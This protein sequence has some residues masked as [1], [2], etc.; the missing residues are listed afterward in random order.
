M[1]IRCKSIAGQR[2]TLGPG[3]PIIPGCELIKG[4]GIFENKEEFPFMFAEVHGVA[5]DNG[6]VVIWPDT[7]NDLTR[8]GAGE[9]VPAGTTLHVGCV[10]E[11]GELKCAP[12]TTQDES[13]AAEGPPETSGND[14]DDG[15]GGDGKGFCVGSG[16]IDKPSSEELDWLN[17][18]ANFQIPDLQAF[19][20]SGFTAMVQEMVGKLSEILGKLTAEVDAI[21][22]KVKIDP[23]DV[24]TPPVKAFIR[25]LLA[26]L[27]ELMKIL[28]IL[29]QIIQI[30]KIIRKIIKLV[31]K[32][33]KWTPPFIV[34]IV[35]ALLKILNLA[36]LIDMVVSILLKTIGRFTAI[37]PIL[38]AQLM[39]I[40]A[41]CAGQVAGE[42]SKEDCEAAGG[43]WIDPDDLKN[44][45]DMYDKMLTETSALD[46]D[47]ES[48]GFC[49]ITE[50]LDK[51]S[52]ED[53]GGTWTDLDTDTNFDDIDTSALSNELNKQMEELERCFSSPELKDYLTEL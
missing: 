1:P 10:I 48:I 12:H 33:L 15:D 4:S 40:L 32:I 39:Q 24:C 2:V 42:M 25:N 50:Y 23:E 26:I 30:V 53:A 21:M 18:I 37:I 13:T 35:E 43:E 51:K 20:L 47:D 41:Q 27:K 29:K 11:N 5:G 7:G 31:K 34:P 38:Q 22:A 19:A 8:Y 9:T 6:A 45:Q 28:P 14:G 44:L 52:C 3:E 17:D 36:G 49:S 16:T 46:T